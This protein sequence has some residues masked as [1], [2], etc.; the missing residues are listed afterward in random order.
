[1]IVPTHDHAATLDIAVNSALDQTVANV[2]VV[3]V[4]DGVGNDT[5]R[6]VAGLA[7]ADSRVRFLDLPKGPSH[8]EVHRGTAV[9]TT[10]AEVVCYLCDDDLL[11]PDHV[12]SMLELLRD[13]DVAN[14]LNGY[15]DLDG[16]WKFYW[17]DLALPESRSW[18]VRPDRNFVSLTG[19]AHTVAAYRR[20]PH[21]WRTTPSGRWVDHYM[22]E[23]FLVQPWVRAATSSRVTAL[24]LPSYI[25]RDSWTDED[26]RSELQR[27]ASLVAD[28]QWRERFHQ[29]ISRELVRQGTRLHLAKDF[30]EEERGPL[31]EYVRWL[32]RRADVAEEGLEWL[33]LQHAAAGDAQR[34]LEQQRLEA[35]A[36]RDRYRERALAAE[37]GRNEAARRADESEAVLAGLRTELRSIEA[38]RT[39]RV[40]NRLV[41]VP[42]VNWLAR[43]TAQ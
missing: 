17:G 1:M 12:E 22:W 13:A 39:W 16:S 21:G 11:M 35:E 25:G 27:W 15:V 31:E 26:R 43:R 14:C 23:Q 36:D 4:G 40:R 3:I 19:T 20:L 8:G 5:R 34:W 10:E 9:E 29:L 33:K 42:L 32:E 7:E 38:T 2:E 6:V 24:Q 30:F 28:P 37:S 41:S 18:T